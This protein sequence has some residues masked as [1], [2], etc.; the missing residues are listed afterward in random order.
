M[1]TQLTPALT[2]TL[3]HGT[4]RAASSPGLGRAPGLA[5][6]GLAAPSPLSCA[7][8]P[9]CTRPVTSR[10]PQRP[11][12]LRALS[13]CAAFGAGGVISPPVRARGRP[14]PVR[15]AVVLALPAQDV[16]AARVVDRVEDVVLAGPLR[17]RGRA[18]E[19]EEVAVLGDAAVAADLQ[20]AHAVLVLRDRH[21]AAVL[22]GRVLLEPVDESGPSAARDRLA[23]GGD[24]VAGRRHLGDRA[25]ERVRLA[26]QHAVGGVD[27]EL[28][29]AAG[30]T[31]HQSA[32]NSAIACAV[33]TTDGRC[34][35]SST[36]C[37]APHRAEAHRGRVAVELEGARVGRGGGGEQRRRLRRSR[38]RRRR[39]GR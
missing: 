36:P 24:A 20:E 31:P 8:P 16:D 39:R 11:R 19:R 38:A 3:A 33:V 4:H 22:E 7:G 15:R 23:V 2:R 5:A 17:R 10:S 1:I 12:Q 32:M 37:M 6:A 21:E 25:V 30:S 9:A 14:R 18:A 35:R 28:A 26:R 29:Y 34:T 27:R 13:T